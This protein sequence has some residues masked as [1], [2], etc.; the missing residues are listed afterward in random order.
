MA[1]RL[2]QPGGRK[3]FSM[4]VSAN[5]Y[6][7]AAGVAAYTRV[8]TSSGSYDATTN[9]T[10]N[11][12]EAWVNQVS[13]ITNAALSSAGFTVPISQ[14]D[15]ILMLT[16]L[17]EQS[18]AD[19]CHAARSSGRFF[20]ERALN[21][22]LSAMG[23]L[24]KEIYEWVETNADGMEGLGAARDTEGGKAT[25]QAGTLSLDFADHNETVY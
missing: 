9:P 11:Q 16:G 24:R 19:L 17:V 2:S 23:Q 15:C 10:L 4:T 18:C 8:Y 14:A 22:N 13:A 3:G 5:S 21:S 20:S 7:T 25:L 1:S 12:V 6:G